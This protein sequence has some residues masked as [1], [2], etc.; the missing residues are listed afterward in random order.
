[1][2]EV[3]FREYEI[4][5]SA[6]SDVYSYVDTVKKA[7]D[8]YNNTQGLVDRIRFNQ[9]NWREHAIPK[10]GKGPQNAINEQ[11]TNNAEIVIALF[12]AKFGEPTEK[13]QSGTL[14]EIETVFKK[15]G[16]VLTYFGN[17]KIVDLD[18][19]EAVQLEKVREFKKTYNGLY[20]EFSSKKTLLDKLKVA[21]QRLA[22]TLKNKE[23]NDLRIVSY[24][25]GELYNELAY[26]YHDFFNSEYMNEKR[27]AIKRLIKTVNGIS[28]VKPVPV[29]VDLTPLLNDKQLDGLTRSIK[30]IASFAAATFPT[31]KIVFDDDFYSLVVDFADKNGIELSDDFMYIGDACY[32]GMALTGYSLSGNDEEKE[33]VEAL[34]DL[35]REIKKYY[36]LCAFIQQYTDKPFLSLVIK[37]ESNLFADDISIKLY[38]EKG[39]VVDPLSLQLN[40]Q[41]IGEIVQNFPDLFEQKNDVDIE[42]MVYGAVRFPNF[43]PYVDYLTSRSTKPDLDYYQDYFEASNKKMYPFL[44]NEKQDKTIIK[45]DLP[46]GIKQFSAQFLCASLMLNRV[47]KSVKYSIVSKSVGHEIKGE[48]KYRDEEE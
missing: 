16:E 36:H 27:E 30:N 8:S 44:I 31:A 19:I 33:K 15:G 10:Y 2:K 34:L 23:A 9:K 41:D 40:E 5:I 24:K 32:S 20:G 28:I 22:T 25:N 18:S 21:L 46:K 45:I 13:Y 11:L 12:G 43:V 3:V 1:M 48:L 17:G 26:I 4:L 35:Q 42:N 14:E 29:N 37:N 39:I 6:P 38:F 47:A 7:I